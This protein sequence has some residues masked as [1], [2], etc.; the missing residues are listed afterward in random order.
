ME[1]VW[2]DVWLPVVVGRRLRNA[3]WCPRVEEVRYPET[4]HVIEIRLPGPTSQCA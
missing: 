2:V 1:F 4:P 3:V